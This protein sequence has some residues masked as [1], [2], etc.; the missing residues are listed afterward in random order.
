MTI[1]I[2]LT[3][4]EGQIKPQT[5]RNFT[6]TL[7]SPSGCRNLVLVSPNIGFG[8]TMLCAMQIVSERAGSIGFCLLAQTNSQPMFKALKPIDINNGVTKVFTIT[9]KQWSR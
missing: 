3:T 7:H 5:K 8:E 4:H 2:R 6:A 1:T 9:F